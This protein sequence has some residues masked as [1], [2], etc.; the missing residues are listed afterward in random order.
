M[1][2]LQED[3]LYQGVWVESENTWSKK[4]LGN[5]S[6]MLLNPSDELPIYPMA[7]PEEPTVNCSLKERI[8]GSAKLCR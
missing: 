3:N 8:S 7:D 2:F 5:S 4:Y 6:A 1:S